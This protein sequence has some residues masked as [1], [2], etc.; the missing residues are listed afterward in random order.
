VK[1][2]VA[3]RHRFFERCRIA[4]ISD[5]GFCLRALG[6]QSFKIFQIAG[7]PNQQAQLRALLGKNASNMR[8]QESRSAGDESFQRQFSVLSLKQGLAD[9][10]IN[11]AAGRDGKR[12]AF[13]SGGGAF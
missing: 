13:S 5:G 4:Q 8:A 2:R 3:T 7:G 1:H 11:D 6:K 9:Q 10:R 12:R